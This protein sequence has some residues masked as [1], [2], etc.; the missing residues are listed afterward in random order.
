M[1]DELKPCPFCGDEPDLYV[2]TAFGVPKGRIEVYVVCRNC[3]IERAES[4]LSGVPLERLAEAKE[5]AINW[6]NDRKR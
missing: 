5:K 4:I 3:N 2:R 1:A 6:W